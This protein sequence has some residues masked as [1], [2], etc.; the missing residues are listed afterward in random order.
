MNIAPILLH[1]PKSMKLN[2]K[3]LLF[4]AAIA[5]ATCA[6]AQVNQ[7]N[8]FA[9]GSIGVNSS[10][11]E[12]KT[13]NVTVEDPKQTNGNV[14]VGAGYFFT[15]NIAAGV[16]I[17]YFGNK[18]SGSGFDQKTN[19]LGGLLF[20]RY[21]YGLS[22]TFYFYGQVDV[23]FAGGKTKT[24]ANNVTVEGPKQNVVAF[25]IRPGFTFFPTPRFGLDFNIGQIGYSKNTSTTT[26]ALNE[27][28]KTTSGNFSAGIDGTNVNFGLMYFFG[29]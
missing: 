26:N 2:M 5:L 10:T 19:L 9:T 3:K 4:S 27:E 18:V 16:G 6:S 11:R 7:G 14:A 24:T 8:I 21:Y 23:L 22:E 15:D 13:G 17:G 20:G 25:A 1:N 28:V 29:R 12:V